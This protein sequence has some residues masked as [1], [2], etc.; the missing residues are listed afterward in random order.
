MATGDEE[1][2][3]WAP[4]P[5]LANRIKTFQD[6]LGRAGGGKQGDRTAR[7]LGVAAESS[8]SNFVRGVSPK[9]NTNVTRPDTIA[10][11]LIRTLAHSEP[12][13]HADEDPAAAGECEYWRCHETERLGIVR[14]LAAEARVAK[15][16]PA[17]EAEPQSAGAV[18]V[19][20]ATAPGQELRQNERGGSRVRGLASFEASLETGENYGSDRAVLMVKPYFD[21]VSV[22]QPGY[23]GCDFALGSC[24]FELEICDGRV[25]KG[26]EGFAREI[27]NLVVKPRG[28]EEG[29][30]CD[31]FQKGQGKWLAENASALERLCDLEPK[32]SEIGISLT[33]PR[34]A[35]RLLDSKDRVVS[36][37]GDKVEALVLDWLRR[38]HLGET[39]EAEIH[40]IEYAKIRRPVD[41]A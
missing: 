20:R 36:A 41:D 19:A 29:P 39:D 9:P 23:D 5:A 15:G 35:L 27:G 30:Y 22:D 4:T 40:V 25:L 13:T 16:L 21:R 12:A 38:K 8:L 7:L 34:S 10:K 26:H 3:W 31:I 37:I 17:L 32:T 14:M 1:R 24:R 18:A 6:G 2:K 33:F 28:P 11:R